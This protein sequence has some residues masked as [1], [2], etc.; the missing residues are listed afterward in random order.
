MKRLAAALSLAALVVCAPRPA[1][2]QAREVRLLVTV[3]DQTN[4]VIPGATVTVTGL[5]PAT[6]KATLAPVQTQPTGLATVTGLV[7]GRYTVRAEFAG[8]DPGTLKEIRL[9]P[10]D[11]RHIVVLA[12]E[13]MQESVDVKQDAQAGAADRRN[14]AFGTVLT[15]EAMDALSDDP[16]EMQR[17]LM[18]M[19]GPGAVMRSTTG[20]RASDETPLKHRPRGR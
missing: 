8:F 2:A 1:S 20:R 6:Q 9:R 19:A 13:K 12:I 5:E 7:P 14:D 15:R 3:I 10:G 17:Q 11:N 4:L 18:E 16:D